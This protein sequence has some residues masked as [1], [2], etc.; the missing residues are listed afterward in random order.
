VLFYVLAGCAGHGCPAV[1]G[2]RT[3]TG[4]VGPAV[5]QRAGVPA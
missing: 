2:A 5:L 3:Y 1:G 4:R